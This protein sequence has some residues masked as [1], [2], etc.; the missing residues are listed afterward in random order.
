[1]SSEEQQT[2]EEEY[3]GEIESNSGLE[4]EVIKDV[5]RIGG[6]R[7]GLAYLKK[8]HPNNP[9]SWYLEICATLHKEVLDEE[10]LNFYDEGEED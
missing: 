9:Q 4:L 6:L 10:I 7:K 1:M 8:L 2:P 3:A 5:I